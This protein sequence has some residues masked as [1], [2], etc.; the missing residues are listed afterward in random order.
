VVNAS[1]AW[2]HYKAE[3]AMSRMARA[4]TDLVTNFVLARELQADWKLPAGGGMFAPFVLN[5]SE[6]EF[7]MQSFWNNANQHT[8]PDPFGMVK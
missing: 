4:G 8:I 1:G 6:Y 5:L 7:L 3:A 2:N